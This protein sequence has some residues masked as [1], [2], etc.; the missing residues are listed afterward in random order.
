MM[1]TVKKK[2]PLAISYF[3]GV[4]VSKNKL[5]YAVMYGRDLMFHKVGANEPA[6]I[7]ELIG[8]LKSI[9]GFRL[10]RALFCMEKTGFYSN[11]LL[12][13]LKKLKTNVFLEHPLRI[14]RSMGL[15]RGKDDKID[16]IRIAV[17]AQRH[18]DLVKLWVPR[19]G[20]LQMLMNLF[21]IR[22]RM[23]G[24]SVSVNTP[25]Q[26]QSA[27][28]S[29]QMHDKSEQLCVNTIEAIKTDLEQLNRFMLKLIEEDAR[30]KR[31]TELI[32][33]VTGIGFVTAVQMI[34]VTNEFTDITNPKKFAC[35]AGVAP[36]KNESGTVKSRGRVSHLANKKMKSLLHIC[37]TIAVR[38]DKELKAYYERKTKVEKKHRMLVLN[39]V[40]NKLILRVFVCV[41]Q[42]RCYQKD[43]IRPVGVTEDEVTADQQA[44][45]SN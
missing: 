43:Y 40:R 23:L 20:E 30:L 32:T 42:D 27:F 15:V 28:F 16:A 13:V 35:Y 45:L 31:L 11:H 18:K 36:F 9:A 7:E 21:T 44:L 5:D 19:R 4:D 29:R 41:N 38:W 34:I 14:R 8:E 6:A 39:A 26:E 17:Y 24:I 33:S 25:L 10:S 1:T 3:I 2:R 22:E 37:A 12:D